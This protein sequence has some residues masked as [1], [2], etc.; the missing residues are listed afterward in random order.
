M[1]NTGW[2]VTKFS[3]KSWKSTK[4]DEVIETLEVTN[5]CTVRNFN[6]DNLETI[7]DLDRMGL[8]FKYI[9]YQ[10]AN[11]TSTSRLT[12]LLVKGIVMGPDIRNTRSC[13]MRAKPSLSEAEN[14]QFLRYYQVAGNWDLVTSN[15]LSGIASLYLNDLI[16]NIYQWES[17]GLSP[18]HFWGYKKNGNLS[19]RQFPGCGTS[20]QT[21]LNM[22]QEKTYFVS[23]LKPIYLN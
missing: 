12:W 5:K 16:E 20:C 1:K 14:I 9:G 15:V 6:A 17:S 11:T 4:E 7:I 3:S 10:K 13:V 2:I 21:T 23:F 8:Y 19:E 22:Q 18:I